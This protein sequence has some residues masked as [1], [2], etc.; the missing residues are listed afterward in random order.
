MIGPCRLSLRAARPKSPAPGRAFLLSGDKTRLRRLSSLPTRKASRPKRNSGRKIQIPCRGITT[1]PGQ[2]AV[3]RGIARLFVTPGQMPPEPLPPSFIST[4]CP[5][6]SHISLD[7]F[8]FSWL[9]SKNFFSSCP[10]SLPKP[11]RMK[12]LKWKPW[13][14]SRDHM[15]STPF[16]PGRPGY[17]QAY[18]ARS[19]TGGNAPVHDSNNS[20]GSKRSHTKICGAK[21]G[22][23][24]ERRFHPELL[25]AGP[26]A[27]EQLQD[28]HAQLK[29]PF[30]FRRCSPIRNCSPLF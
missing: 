26:A 16:I 18:H 9:A 3:E 10:S 24:L 23:P 21:A 8:S 19:R 6:F 30:S 1:L 17:N 15:R 11:V 5:P 7:K 12:S 27:P 20:A 28:N 13:G 25:L 4:D 29:A 14:R 22:R 2:T